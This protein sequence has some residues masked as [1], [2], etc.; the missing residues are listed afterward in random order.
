MAVLKI[1]FS[2]THVCARK[3]LISLKK[4]ETK[5]LGNLKELF[6]INYP[7]HLN[8]T[9]II[10]VFIERIEKYPQWNERVDFLV[11][12]DDSWRSNGVFILIIKRSKIYFDTLE[13][14]PYPALKN[15]LVALK[16]EENATF[17]NISDRLRSLLLDI[18]RIQHLKIIHDIGTKAF[19]MSREFL[20]QLQE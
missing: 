16:M 9:S 4:L 2:R 5:S 15:A 20:M 1:Y 11:N 3:M 10:Q 6:A 14:A 18:I 12:D 17:I 19:L 13:D 7:K 8:T